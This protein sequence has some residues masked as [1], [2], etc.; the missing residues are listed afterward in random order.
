MKRPC[1]VCG[2]PSD[3][4]RCP[5]HTQHN[6]N[7]RSAH[8][9]TI[10]AERLAIDNGE[11]QLQHPGCTRVATSVHL[12]PA[13]GGNHSLATI[14]NTVSAC[15]HCHGVEDGPRGRG[16]PALSARR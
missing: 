4:P 1:L 6:Y 3:G 14:H 9:R 15:A 8:W 2:T 11:C 13:A 5:E 7:P 16:Y 10:R 12:D